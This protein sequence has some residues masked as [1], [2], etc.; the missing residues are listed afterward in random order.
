M[1]SVPDNW[2]VSK[3]QYRSTFSSLRV[4]AM[5]VGPE[6]VN[7][8]NTHSYT[9]FCQA[10]LSEPRRDSLFLF[11]FFWSFGFIQFIDF[12]GCLLLLLSFL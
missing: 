11:D 5:V 10:M 8:S 4:S 1:W 12:G 9:A 3:L 7:H 2:L 6:G